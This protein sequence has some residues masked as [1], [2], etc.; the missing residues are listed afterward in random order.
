[1]AKTPLYDLNAFI[2]ACSNERNVVVPRSVLTD[3]QKLF[4]LRSKKQLLDAIYAKDVRITDFVNCNDL[5]KNHYKDTNGCIIPVR[6]DAYYFCYTNEEGYL[7]F[8]IIPI[9]PHKWHLKSFHEPNKNATTQ[10]GDC[11][12]PQIIEKLKKIGHKG[13]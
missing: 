5:E 3:A 6:A 2:N 10:L 9:P 8:Y 1:M 11:L 4:N 12:A 13:N 7:A